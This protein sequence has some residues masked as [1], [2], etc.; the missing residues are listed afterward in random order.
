MK[1]LGAMFIIVAVVCGIAAFTQTQETEL[2]KLNQ[3]LVASS[4][5]GLRG[6]KAVD[7]FLDASAQLQGQRPPPP[8]TSEQD[9]FRESYSSALADAEKYKSERNQRLMLWLAG[10]AVFLLAGIVCV[11]SA[12]KPV[13]SP[14]R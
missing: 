5:D 6:T 3:K 8:H 1:P 7:K 11:A 12:Y 2:E 13:P 10:A 4:Q 14:T 9:D